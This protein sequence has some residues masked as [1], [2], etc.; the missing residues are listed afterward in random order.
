MK[1]RS[2]F[3]NLLAALKN[4]F[5]LVSFFSVGLAVFNGCDVGYNCSCPDVK[6]FFNFRALTVARTLHEETP[7][8]VYKIEIK[9]DSIE[10]VAQLDI[11]QGW[12]NPFT[13][14]LYACSCADEGYRG[15]KVVPSALDIT[16]DQPFS[17]GLPAGKSLAN[18]CRVGSNWGLTANLAQMQDLTTLAPLLP[19]EGNN[20][21]TL[22]LNLVPEE[23]PADGIRFTVSMLLADNTILRVTTE[24]IR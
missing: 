5:V 10:Y 18:F 21:L 6:P 17:A 19:Y 24:P 23:L 11:P 12:S 20:S 7:Q 22:F 4:P 15:P 1:H 9:L 16:A 3:C 13:T 8:A 2:I 14:S